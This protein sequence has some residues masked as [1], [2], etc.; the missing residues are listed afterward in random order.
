MSAT[1]LAEHC[2]ICPATGRRI[3]SVHGYWVRT[4]PGCSHRWAE[5]GETESVA[6]HVEAVYDDRYFTGGGA[7]YVDYLSLGGLIRAHGRR[8]G[9]LLNRF[10]EPG[11]VLDVGAAAG[12]ILQ[13]F[14]DAGWTGEGLEPNSRLVRHAR[15]VLGVSVTNTTLEEYAGTRR[16]DVVSMI[17]VLPHFI[18]PVQALKCAARLTSPGGYWLI[19]TWDRR[20]WTAR[21]LGSRWHEYSPPSVLHWFTPSS[22]RNLAVQFGFEVV[23]Y[24]HPKKK[25]IGAHLKSM[26]KF[27]MGG[28]GRPWPLE[29]ALSVVPD[30]LTLSYPSEDLFWMILRHRG[31]P[32][33]PNTHNEAVSKEATFASKR[34]DKHSSGT[35]GC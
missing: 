29:R 7:G 10:M 27:K 22:V 23:G 30:D 28:N 2:P 1:T 31:H 8:Y 5:I 4:C 17:Q 25:F 9:R 21:I 14:E 35:D 34:R 32:A 6:R 26:I 11:S 16:F 20:S 3:F 33:S 15:H 19:E 18:D 13:G 24:G 12:F